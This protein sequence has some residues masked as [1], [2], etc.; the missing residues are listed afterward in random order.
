[1]PAT[2][3]MLGASGVAWTSLRNG[4]YAS[5]AVYL[6][7]DAAKTGTIKAPVDG[8]VAWTDHDDLAA[9]AARQSSPTR[10][11]MMDRRRRSRLLKHSTSLT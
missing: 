7:G 1:M 5:S 3:E 2:E 6:I 9:A 8:K 11:D 10:A 4:F